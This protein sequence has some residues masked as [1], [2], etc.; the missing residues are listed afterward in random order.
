[1][2]TTSSTRRRFATASLVALALLASAGVA[3]ATDPAAA[4]AQL[5]AGYELKDQGKYAEAIPHLE[6]SLRLDPQLKALTNLADCEEHTGALVN[7]QRHWL[8]ARDRASAEGNDRLKAAADA[9]LA[10]LEER[11]PKL[12]I[13][14]APDAP[15]R[16]EVVRDGTPLG[17][18]SL[19]TP[20]PTDIG[21]HT[22]VARAPGFTE[23]T[24]TVTLAEKEQKELVVHPGG[25]AKEAPA[26]T[27]VPAP[28]PL[29]AR[30]SAWSA[31]RT[32]ALVSGGVGVVALAVGAGF[33]ISTGT[34]WSSAQHE[35]GAGCSPSSSAQAERSSALTDATASD[36]AFAV[37]GAAV[38]AGVILWFTAPKSHETSRAIDA[39]TVL[40]SVGPRQVGVAA[41]LTF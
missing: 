28:A 32:A 36:V 18:V 25:E 11:L 22:V 12:T 4:R 17:A 5:Q 29:A 41:G 37:A 35:C 39:F 6:E 19:G 34:K 31:N 1:M 16:T 24:F 14:V 7:A 40:P 9:R 8:M 38:A 13:K 30:R 23:E 3:Y 21:T 15:P 26:A 10:A 27:V 33:G 2:T 20:L